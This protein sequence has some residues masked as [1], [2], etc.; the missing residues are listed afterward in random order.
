[1]KQYRQN[2]KMAEKYCGKKIIK[3]I[4]CENDFRKTKKCFD[5]HKLFS[6]QFVKKRLSNG[7]ESE[8]EDTC[9]SVCK[10]ANHYI[11]KF[12]HLV[13]GKIS[14]S[15]TAISFFSSFDW[16]SEDI[17]DDDNYDGRNYNDR[18]FR[19]KLI[20]LSLSSKN[21]SRLFD[22][23]IELS[24]IRTTYLIEAISAFIFSQKTQILTRYVLDYCM[25]KKELM[26]ASCY[27]REFA[28]KT[29]RIKGSVEE[30]KFFIEHITKHQSLSSKFYD[31]VIEYKNV[32]VAKFLI[33]D[34]DRILTDTTL[35]S[36]WGRLKELA[37]SNTKN[38]DNLC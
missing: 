31:A 36:F 19:T 1:M 29:V 22:A 6:R 30:V 28:T 34:H 15:M 27:A 8:N 4:E 21:D 3:Q 24:Q 35:H 5:N 26:L 20:K 2:R 14:G 32:E 10:N 33:D 17:S 12:F 23:L 9:V 18:V 37:S 16:E 11:V 38:N 25:K 13:D 7:R